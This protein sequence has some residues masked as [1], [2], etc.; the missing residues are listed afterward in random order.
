MRKLLEGKLKNSRH[1]LKTWVK[2][3]MLNLVWVHTN[4][5]TYVKNTHVNK[6]RDNAT[7]RVLLDRFYVYQTDRASQVDYEKK[8]RWKYPISRKV[9]NLYCPYLTIPETLIKIHFRTQI[10][11]SPVP[12]HRNKLGNKRSMCNEAGL[13]GLW[14]EWANWM[15]PIYTKNC[16][17]KEDKMRMMP[18]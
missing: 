12:P 10:P 8:E 17:Q 9:S 15:S 1:N 11:F 13:P 18:K 14:A 2:A 3:K 16:D 6:N 5:R 4:K 7:S